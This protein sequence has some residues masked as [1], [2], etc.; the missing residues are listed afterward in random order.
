MDGID[1]KKYEDVD[2]DQCGGREIGLHRGVFLKAHA[3]SAVERTLL[4]SERRG[5]QDPRKVE[6]KA[7]AEPDA[8]PKEH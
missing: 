1:R 5:R 4:T 8:T 3:R 7:E 6:A 2:H